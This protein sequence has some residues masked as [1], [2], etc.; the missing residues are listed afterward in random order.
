M[1]SW[2][3]PEILQRIIRS[4][5]CILLFCTFAYFSTILPSMLGLGNYEPCQEGLGIWGSVGPLVKLLGFQG[6]S[7]G[8]HF[9]G[10]LAHWSGWPSRSAWSDSLE[11]G[12]DIMVMMAVGCCCGCFC[13]WWWWW[14]WCW[15]LMVDGWWWL[16]MVDD[17][18]DDDGD[19]YG[20][21]DGEEEEGEDATISTTRLQHVIAPLGSLASQGNQ[22]LRSARGSDV[23]PFVPRQCPT[24]TLWHDLK[25]IFPRFRT[26]FCSTTISPYPSLL[27]LKVSSSELKQAHLKRIRT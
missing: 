7:T 23:V 18:D 3:F 4:V 15:W 1:C 6:Q 21:D 26:H 17:D 19:D 9:D 12:D 14:W 8:P 5:N 25:N 22:M 10:W 24:H 16:M 11:K 2:T 27:I 13:C 20:D